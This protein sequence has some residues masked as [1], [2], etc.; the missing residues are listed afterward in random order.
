MRLVQTL[1]V[2]D[3]VDV[4]GA[5]I[6]YH[7]RAGVDFVLAADHGSTDGTSEV[8][9]SFARDGCLERIP[10]T[11]EMREAA[12]R[13]EM[14]RRAATELG[15]DW[16]INTDA[17]EFWMPRA[18]TLKETLAAVPDQFGVVWAISRHFVPRPDDDRLF[19]ERM[20]VRLSTPTAINDPTSPFRPHAKVAHRADAEIR[21]RFGAHLV[22]SE[23]EPLHDWFV[24]D[25]LH[26]PYRSRVQYERKGV[27]R[28]RGDKPLGQYVKAYQAHEVGRVDD[29]YG[30]IVVDDATL[31]RG[32][33]LRCL[34]TDTR[35]RDA[36]RVV[37]D[38]RARGPARE[39][40]A[41]REPSEVTDEAGLREA[42][43][44]RTFRRIDGLG[45]RVG[46]VEQRGLTRAAGRLGGLSHG[47]PRR[48]VGDAR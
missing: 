16:V 33:A 27:R 31:E 47:R 23:L 12:W 4:V 22:F 20:T 46:A 10:V 32:L 34:V 8:L 2:R 5:Q 29:V 36:L 14:A 45:A 1:V 21:I 17:D 39:G 40:L 11:G 13:T 42:D 37:S 44:V 3:E 6:A 15:A 7:L 35:L 9:E 30:S 43:L 38:A 26:F 24:A 28:A 41:A 18:G 25:V 48:P 19:A